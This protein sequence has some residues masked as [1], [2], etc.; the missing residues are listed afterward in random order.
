[1]TLFLEPALHCR[2]QVD[3]ELGE[4]D[5]KISH[6]SIQKEG[7]CLHNQLRGAEALRGPFLSVNGPEV[8]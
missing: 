6:A 4:C 8:G 7:G 5:Y 3:G 1:V 2:K